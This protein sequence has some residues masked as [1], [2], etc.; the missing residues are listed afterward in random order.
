MRVALLKVL[1][2]LC[3][4]GCHDWA[5]FSL[6]YDGSGVATDASLADLAGSGGPDGPVMGGTCGDQVANG[7]ESDIDCG[8]RCPSCPNG[9][10]CLA[11]SD[12]ASLT[13]LQKT[14]Y[15]QTCAN[16]VKG[17]RETDVDCGGADCLPCDDGKGC[18]ADG[19]CVS[20][21]CRLGS[22]SRI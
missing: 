11:S 8:G 12:C 7:S 21:H 5:A 10:R 17:Q 4:A 22:C 15:P 13:C 20:T 18:V 3:L 16:S 14:C 19:D 1:C 9:R 2:V 6:N